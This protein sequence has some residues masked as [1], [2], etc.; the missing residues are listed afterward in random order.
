MH[1]LATAR[2]SWPGWWLHPDTP[3]DSLPT[4]D[5]HLTHAD[6]CCLVSDSAQCYLRS[7]DVQTCVVTRTYSSY[8]DIT[9]AV[10]RSR[11]WDSLTVQLRNPDI[12]YRL[13][14]RQLT[15]HLFVNHVT[16]DMQRLRKTFTYL[17]TS[18]ITRQCHGWESVPRQWVPRPNHYTTTHY[19]LYRPD[20]IRHTEIFWKYST[21][22]RSIPIASDWLLHRPNDPNR[23][24]SL[25]YGFLCNK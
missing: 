2:L 14:R 20:V 21:W 18:K 6:D 16:F 4:K 3:Q 10:A 15:G 12:T 9:F 7:A 1:D 25:R 11:S 5:D 19:T 13:L 8:G 24:A 22:Q 23:I 17:L